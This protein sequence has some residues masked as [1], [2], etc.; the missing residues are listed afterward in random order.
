MLVIRPEG[1]TS[2]ERPKL[3]GGNNGK[4]VLNKM[5]RGRRLNSCG[6]EFG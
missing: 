4:T 6:P 2:L 3:R 5:M 1:K